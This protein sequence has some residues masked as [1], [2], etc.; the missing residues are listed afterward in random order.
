[1]RQDTARCLE[2]PSTNRCRQHPWRAVLAL[3]ALAALASVAA[4]LADAQPGAR[5]TELAASG[6]CVTPTSRDQPD[7][8]SAFLIHVVYA[9]PSDEPDRFGER[10]QRILSDLATIDAWWRSEDPTRAPR[11]DL[12]PAACDP[13]PG[14]LD[15]SDVRL[16]HDSVYYAEPTQGFRRITTDLGQAPTSFRSPDKKYLVYYDGTVRRHDVC[17]TSPLGPARASGISI[18]YLDS[19]CG[20][21]LGSGRLAAATA[22]HELLHNIGAIPRTHPCVGNRAHACDS[23]SD[24]LYYAVEEGKSLAGLHLDVGHDDYYGLGGGRA[25][26]QDVRDSP[27]LERVGTAPTQVPPEPSGFDATG[28]CTRVT[29]SWPAAAGMT[30]SVY[31][32][33]RDGELLSETTKRSF[34]DSARIGATVY[35]VRVADAD[36]YLSSARTIR[37]TIPATEIGALRTR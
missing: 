22:V 11:L 27:F 33:Y 28:A 14:R 34:I 15:L 24:V 9:V 2:Q 18:V 23:T 6:S 10:V 25:P 35:A 5:V 26:G 37:F 8:V 4:P 29:L 31:R 12:L 19:F 16:S 3:A 32:V 36:G 30:N 21:D 7:A 20:T 13:T 1:V 17:G